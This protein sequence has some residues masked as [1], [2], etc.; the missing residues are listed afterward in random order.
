MHILG[1]GHAVGQNGG[2][3]RHDGAPFRQGLADGLISNTNKRRA[4]DRT[5]REELV[6]LVHK[7]AGTAASFGEPDLG[8][9]ACELERAMKSAEG[10]EECEAIAFALLALA[11]EPPS[12]SSS[13]K[14]STG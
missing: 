14:Q 11:D 3:E 7:L 9:R 1:K 10:G 4:R 2:F 13:P 6:R 5:D 8:E 12:A